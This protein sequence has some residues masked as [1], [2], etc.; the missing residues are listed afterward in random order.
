MYKEMESG[1][2]ELVLLDIEIPGMNG[3]Q[4]AKRVNMNRTTPYLIFVSA[5]ES[6]FMM[7]RSLYRYGL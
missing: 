3:F 4:L 2:F 6:V 1:R 7:P 5:Y